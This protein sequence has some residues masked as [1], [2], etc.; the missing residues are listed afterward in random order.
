VLLFLARDGY[1]RMYAIYDT[2]RDTRT[3]FATTQGRKDATSGSEA[4]YQVTETHRLTR[5]TEILCW[6][7]FC[8]ELV[9]LFVVPVCVLIR[10][11]NFAIA[12]LFIFL[13]FFSA[14]RHY[15]NAPV[16][17]SELGSLDVSVDIP[18]SGEISFAF[19]AFTVFDAHH[20][21]AF[22][23]LSTVARWCIYSDSRHRL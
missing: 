6:I 7:L 20:H 5:P 17:L 21:I 16:L 13:A 1:R 10:V 9:G 11:G 22:S 3:R 18:F 8:L 19:L 2:Y 4:I 15:C 23:F 12:I 14:M